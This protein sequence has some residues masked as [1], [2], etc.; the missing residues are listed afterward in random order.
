MCAIFGISGIYDYEQTLK[1]FHSQHKRGMDSHS[2]YKTPTL[3]IGHH[4]LKIAPHSVEQPF[5]LAHHRLIV[6]FNGEIYN[7][8]DIQRELNHQCHSE[9]E[10]IAYAFLRWNKRFIRHIDGAFAIVIAYHDEILIFRDRMGKKPLFYSHHNNQFIWAST[11]SPFIMLQGLTLDP[12]GVSEWFIHQGTLHSQTLLANVYQLPSGYYGRW[13]NHQLT[14][15]PY[16]NLHS[17][18]F[19]NTPFTTFKKHLIH[20]VEKRLTSSQGAIFLSGG[21]DSALIAAITSQ[22]LCTSL[23]TFS[24]GFESSR[25]DES[26]YAN[27]CATTL[28][29]EHD[30]LLFTQELFETLLPTLSH[31]DQPIPDPSF[32]PLLALSHHA[33]LQGIKWTFSGEGGDELFWGYRQ[34]FDHQAYDAQKRHDPWLNDYLQRHPE[35]TREWERLSRI[36][37]NR[38]CYQSLELFTPLQWKKLNIFDY[39]SPLHYFELLFTQT[40]L[41]PEQWYGFIDRHI[42][43]KELLLVKTDRATMNAGIEARNPFCDTSLNTFALTL[44]QESLGNHGITKIL[45]RQLAREYYPPSITERLKKGFSYPFFDYLLAT[46]P[47]WEEINRHEL[48]PTSTLLSLIHKAHTDRRYRPKVW[49]FYVFLSWYNQAKDLPLTH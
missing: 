21:I 2:Y 7:F 45:P 23:P 35:P 34:Y 41:P 13:K 24:I 26:S 10:L 6:A 27:L 36:S 25:Y 31:S 47:L 46:N 11:L 37:A 29:L 30:T 48:I 15:K 22:E 1:A 18:S 20:A 8:H 44:T 43:L 19:E 38:S 33:K 9:A 39:T 28:H 17:D 40:K 4:R 5:V 3:F 16:E 49:A 12:Q 14:I 32:L 42:Y